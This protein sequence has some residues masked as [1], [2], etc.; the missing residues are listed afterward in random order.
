MYS[1]LSFSF[2]AVTKD[3]TTNTQEK[4]NTTLKKRIYV[5][6]GQKF[7]FI[8]ILMILHYFRTKNTSEQR[9]FI[10]YEPSYPTLSPSLYLL[11][12]FLISF[13][14]P[15]FPLSHLP[16]LSPLSLSHS[17]SFSLSLSLSR[18][19]SS[20]SLPLSISLSLSFSLSLPLSSLSP[21]R[22]WKWTE[23]A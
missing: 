5:D 7:K 17:L 1:F 20:P 9:H 2:W 22:H 21:S 4:E 12:T 15:F 13:Y 16:L 19:M 8:S 23:F 3:I 18:S 14:L 10:L 6:T 11:L